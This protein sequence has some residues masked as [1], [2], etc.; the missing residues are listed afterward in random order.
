MQIQ[1]TEKT[2]LPK[3][4]EIKLAQL[5]AKTWADENFRQRF[6]AEPVKLLREVGIVFEDSIK[7]IVNQGASDSLLFAG[8]EAGTKVCEIALPSKPKDLGAE[9][10]GALFESFSDV[11][12][13]RFSRFSTC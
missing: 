10:L 13:T 3:E 11:S 7:V 6:I 1:L 4:L 2:S 8:A 9:D 5:V 12:C